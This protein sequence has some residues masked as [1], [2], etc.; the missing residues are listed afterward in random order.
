MYGGDIAALG[1]VFFFLGTVWFW[2]TSAEG[3]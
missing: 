3:K 2:F 1:G